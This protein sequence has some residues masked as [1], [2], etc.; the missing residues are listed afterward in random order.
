MKTRKQ[1]QRTGMRRERPAQLGFTLVE[2][3]VSLVLG[4]ILTGAVLNAF[5]SSK[6]T[7]A[8]NENLSRMQ[9]NS[10][11]GFELLSR[12]IRE[13]GQN[14]CGTNQMG[15]VIRVSGAIPWWAN[16]EA[17]VIRGFEGTED[18]TDIVPIGTGT[19]Q[20]VSGTD[21]ILVLQASSNEQTIASHDVAGREITLD[22]ITGIDE[23]DVLVI[24]DLNSAV[25]AQ[26]G[27]IS[28]A[29]KKINYDPALSINCSANLGSPTPAACTAVPAKTFTATN[30]GKVAD[31]SSTFWYVGF[32]GR[33]N[34]SL[35]RRI[36]VNKTVSGTKTWVAET[37]EIVPGVQSLQL[38]YLTKSAS[39]GTLATDWVQSDDASL[40][41]S[42]NGWKPTNDN[43]VV[44]VRLQMTFQSED[45][46]G[47][48]N[49]PVQRQMFAVVGLR[50]RATLY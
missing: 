23:A 11:F 2:L 16:W 31:L 3:M 33:G 10:R 26:A 19:G 20:R 5:L 14:P 1:L 30:G 46:V 32:N 22:A 48:T 36:M 43:Q 40:D 4:L 12:S 13:A 39:S 15:N 25:I 21:A 9:E 38:N 50:T 7:F 24:C 45:R 49:A 29:Q 42:V 8:V 34:R 28:V 6:Q 18:V 17:G 41:A 35:Y 27:A 37:Q 47:V 44:A